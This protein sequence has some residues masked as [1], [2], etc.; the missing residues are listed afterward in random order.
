[1]LSM[2][3]VSSNGAHLLSILDLSG[4]RA[5]SCSFYAA[6]LHIQSQGCPRACCPPYRRTS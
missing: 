6:Q 5:S 2:S 3:L 4:V 1:M